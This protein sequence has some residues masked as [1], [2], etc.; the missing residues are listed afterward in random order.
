MLLDDVLNFA[1]KSW[2]ARKQGDQIGNFLH[3]VRLFGSDAGLKIIEV[4]M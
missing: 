1:K 2:P 3:L 4:H